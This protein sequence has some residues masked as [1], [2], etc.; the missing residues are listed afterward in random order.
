MRQFESS[1]TAADGLSLY[2]QGWDDQKNPKAVVCLVH[3]LGDHSGR[4][5]HLARALNAAGYSVLA[6]DQ[7][8]HGRSEGP[9]GH[10]P[11]FEAYMQ[12]IDSLLTEA[13]RRYPGRPRFLYGHSLGGLLVLNYVLRRKPA[14][15]GVVASGP[16]LKSAL[17]EQKVKVA[18]A[19][20]GGKIAPEISISSGLDV[21]LLCHERQV[22]EDYVHDPLV[23]FRVTLGWA[24][25]ML[26]EHSYARLHAKELEIPVLLMH[27]TADQLTSS[28]GSQSFAINSGDLCTLKLWEGLYHEIHNEPEKEQVFAYLI[29]WLDQ[30]LPDGKTDSQH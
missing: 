28:E 21:N 12:D 15:T 6:I 19:R 3:G 24:S 8:G 25:Q 23:H 16:G 27:G 26:S 9:R 22:I 13:S 30:H 4:Y 1:L 11:D 20:L 18:I 2:L 10:I 7:R 14:L 29:D 17:E 5:A